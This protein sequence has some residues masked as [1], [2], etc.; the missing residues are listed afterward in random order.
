MTEELFIIE[1]TAVLRNEYL[2]FYQ[3][4]VASGETMIPWVID[5]DPTDF[6]GMIAWLR[7]AAAGKDLPSGWVPHSTFW[8]INQTNKVLGVVNIRHQLTEFLL[9]E[10]GHVG[11]GIRPTER[12]K[13]YATKLLALSLVEARALGIQRVL[14]TCDDDNIGSE[15]TILN[16]GGVPD[17]NYTNDS[18]LVTKRFWI[19]L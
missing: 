19:E 17:K 10:G 4:W 7:N 5:K 2:A 9:Q 3:E 14:V 16:N 18:G 6:E 8:L 12:R 1:P 13:G 11:Y 15:R